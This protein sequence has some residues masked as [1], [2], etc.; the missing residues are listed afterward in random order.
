MKNKGALNTVKEDRNILLIINRKISKWIHP[1]HVIEEKIK[2]TGRR[3]RRRRK[4]CK[5]LLDDFKETRGY[6][7]LKEETLDRLLWRPRFGGSYG[8]VVREATFW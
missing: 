3:T 1:K 2:G 4:R 8:H 5:Q 6:C 7:K